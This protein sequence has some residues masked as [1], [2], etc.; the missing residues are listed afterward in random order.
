MGSQVLRENVWQGVKLTFERGLAEHERE[1]Y[2]VTLKENDAYT[3]PTSARQ[4]RVLWGDAWIS[5][6]RGDFV[7]HQ[8]ETMDFNPGEGI[9]II[10]GLGKKRIGLEVYL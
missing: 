10:T 8:G 5:Y 1:S 2:T 3:L 4:I 9:A 6:R 7:A